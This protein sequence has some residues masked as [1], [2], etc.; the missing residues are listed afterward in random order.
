MIKQ[1]LIAVIGSFM[2]LTTQT[3]LAND[4]ER[5]A[6]AVDISAVIQNVQ[7]KGYQDIREV[8]FDDGLYKVKAINTDRKTVN[9]Y[10]DPQKN[11]ILNIKTGPKIKMK[12]K[13][14]KLS[15]LDAIKK[16]EATDYHTVYKINFKHHKYEVKALDKEDKKTELQ[17]NANTGEVSKND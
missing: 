3:V 16:V 8:E 7:A 6:N 1:I 11:E 13:A 5:P 12:N 14:P 2:L 4:H 9:I 15:I 17:V 10:V